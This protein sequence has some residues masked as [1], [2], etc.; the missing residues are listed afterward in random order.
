MFLQNLHLHNFGTGKE[1]KGYLVFKE[2]L[3]KRNFE[4]LRAKNLIQ[5]QYIFI[6]S[7]SNTQAINGQNIQY[8]IRTHISLLMRY[9]SL[10]N[11]YAKLDLGLLLKPHSMTKIGNINSSME[12]RYMVSSIYTSVIRQ[13]WKY[14]PTYQYTMLDLFE[15]FESRFLQVPNDHVILIQQ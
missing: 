10:E 5:Q 9:R 6:F 4:N 11:E 3:S 15:F 12:M 2:I 8:T 1:N 14:C 13:H 7:V